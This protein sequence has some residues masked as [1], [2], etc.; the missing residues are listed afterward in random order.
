VTQP[1]QPL[2]DIRDAAGVPTAETGGRRGRVTGSFFHMV[3]VAEE[4][5]P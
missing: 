1:D 2:A 3:D 5:R 4:S